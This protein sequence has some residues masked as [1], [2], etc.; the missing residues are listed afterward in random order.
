LA[1]PVLLSALLFGCGLVGSPDVP[2][3]P[4][5]VCE[6]LDEDDE[7]VDLCDD[8]P[9]EVALCE[10]PWDECVEDPV[11]LGEELACV[12]ECPVP[13]VAKAAPLLTPNERKTT[14]NAAV[15][16]ASGRVRSRN[17][18]NIS[19]HPTPDPEMEAGK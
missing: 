11:A 14:A 15:I 7:L 17:A 9:V 2:A 6:L 1:P 19:C 18:R 5:V 12:D 13:G 8:E 16:A 4:D 3:V 10:D